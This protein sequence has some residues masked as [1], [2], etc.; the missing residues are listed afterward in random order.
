MSSDVVFRACVHCGAAA[1]TGLSNGTSVVSVCARCG[2]ARLAAALDAEAQ[3]VLR[4]LVSSLTAMSSGVRAVCAAS[5]EAFAVADSASDIALSLLNRDGRIATE[6][7][8][9]VIAGLVGLRA[10]LQQ[11]LR[12]HETAH[13]GVDA[14]L[15]QLRA[16]AARCGVN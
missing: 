16:T 3:H 4:D 15:E 7:H 9:T 13:E 6:D 5:R 2:G 14:A 12:A 11:Q 1:E 8:D 10:T